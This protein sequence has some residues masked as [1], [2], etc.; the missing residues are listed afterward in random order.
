M[1][2]VLQHNIASTHTHTHTT[3]AVT[4]NASAVKATNVLCM[5]HRHDKATLP[6]MPRQPA[7]LPRPLPSPRLFPLHVVY[8]LPAW[9][10]SKKKQ[11]KNQKCALKSCV[12]ILIKMFSEK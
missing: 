7:C 6:D 10:Y 1:G 5:L 11:E 4:V 3:K 12:G 9:V 8:N 2:V